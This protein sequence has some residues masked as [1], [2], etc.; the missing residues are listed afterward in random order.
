MTLF[1]GSYGY[2]LADGEDSSIS[3]R[4]LPLIGKV[5]DRFQSYN[6]EMVEVT[7]GRFWKPYADIGP[8]LEKQGEA[9]ASGSKG[10]NPELFGYRPPVDLNN[11]R[12]RNLAAALSPA[13]VRTSGSWANNTYFPESDTLPTK[14]PDGFGGVLSREQWKKLV[15]FS[16]EVDAPIITSFAISAG[17]RDSSG[18]WTSAQAERFL[19]YTREINGHIAAAEFMNEP[20]APAIGG[21]PPGYD[22]AAYGRDFKVFHKFL[23]K[24]A[25]DIQIL[26]PGSVGENDADWGMSHTGLPMVDTSELLSAAGR[27]IDGFSYHH[28]SAVS[29]RCAP[30]SQTTE[31]AALSEQW[32][33]RTEIS[34]AFYR[35][36]RDSFEP[37][38]P[39]WLTETGDAACGG[40][41]WAATFRDTF[42]YL[43]QLGRL[44]KQGVQMVA[45][46]TLVASD[47]G[48][49]DEHD[50]TPRPNYWA[51][52]LWSKTMGA[53]VLEAGLKNRVGLHIYAHCT[54]SVP[55]SVSLLVIN[56]DETNASSI[57]LPI[58]SERYTLSSSSGLS[59]KD[60]MLNGKVLAVSD[61]D[62]VP[63]FDAVQVAAGRVR[64]DPATIT[65]LIVPTAENQACM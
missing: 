44:A 17:V 32:L 7:G 11:K 18:A 4:Y 25:S 39:I 10:M 52:A 42:R 35:K 50:F 28:Y 65:F 64:F 1:S 36:L 63:A 16:N 46:N 62:T 6:V 33:E 5:D 23:R 49:I 38:K 47:Y 31:Q 51:A 61:N 54:R 8:V 30:A 21:A 56:N 9:K 15:D 12:L 27:G 59:T 2:A 14:I 48:L 57:E 53:A 55:G 43:D 37:G 22:A 26:G 29:Q 40:N 24:T 34:L 3:P 60:V 58:P 19:A 41:P 13:Y 45:H 20:N